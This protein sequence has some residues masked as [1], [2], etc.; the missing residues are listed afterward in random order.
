MHPTGP[1]PRPDTRITL[2]GRGAAAPSGG[3]SSPP[4]RVLRPQQPTESDDSSDMQRDFFISYN[5]ADRAWA[6]WIAWELEEAGYTTV[7]QAWDFVPGS[8]FVVEMNEAAKRAKRTIAVLSPSY[9]AASFT[10]A[11]WASAFA[12]DPTGVHRKL[13][14]VRVAEFEPRGLL[15]QIVY[16]DL[17]GLDEDRAGERLRAGVGERLKPSEPPA[18][19]GGARA[20][21]T[22][23]TFPGKQETAAAAAEPSPADAAISL[24]LRTLARARRKRW[25]YA[26]AILVVA[27][28]PIGLLLLRQPHKF[29]YSVIVVGIC[30]L[31]LAAASL[32]LQSWKPVTGLIAAAA[33]V[34]TLVAL[35]DLVPEPQVTIAG[36]VTCA[37]AARVVGVYINSDSDQDGRTD[38]ITASRP[39]VASY[40]YRL[41]K[42]SKFK[43]GVG[44]GGDPGKWKDSI[45]SDYAPSEDTNFIC[46]DG[47]D[48]E[49]A[50]E[51]VPVEG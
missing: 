39:H 26:T 5:S 27:A 41:D 33:A 4:S 14:P 28:V 42:G 3:R 34:L 30:A 8:N 35:Y 22:S 2:S 48:G 1:V 9:L 50:K 21:E 46:Y 23:P 40:S 10:Q 18:F 20:G 25:H 44:C 13:V 37:N 7:L 17:V 45:S 43:I 51:C 32:V 38:P 11:E 24:L 6:E 16:L 15:G 31:A 12:D 49:H 47:R 19:P 36:T 29:P